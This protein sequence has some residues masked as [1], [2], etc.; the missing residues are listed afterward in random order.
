MLFNVRVR[1]KSAKDGQVVD[2]TGH[3]LRHGCV[4]PPSR[5]RSDMVIALAYD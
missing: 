5:P 2:I 4:S 1:Q 3:G